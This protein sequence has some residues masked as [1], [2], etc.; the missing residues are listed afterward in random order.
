VPRYEEVIENSLG[1]WLHD[2]SRA[3]AGRLMIE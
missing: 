3:A 2:P 1:H